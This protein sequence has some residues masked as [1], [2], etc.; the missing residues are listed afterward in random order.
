MTYLFYPYFWGRKNHWAE[1]ITNQNT[2]PL[3]EQFLQASYSRV[4]V[5]VRPGFD[6]TILHY[7]KCGGEPWTKKEPP[8]V[9]EPDDP[10]TCP[11][12]PTVALIDEIKEQLG[13]NFEFRQYSQCQK[14]PQTGD[15]NGN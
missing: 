9:G 8:I 7:I 2:D 5:H 11:H 12:A 3:F 10:Y 4:W 14:E 15:R 13:V 6:G 1:T